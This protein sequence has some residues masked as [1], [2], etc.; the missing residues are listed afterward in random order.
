ME[1]LPAGSRN[2][3]CLKKSVRAVLFDI[4]GTLFI[5]GSGDISSS[6]EK[7]Q[8]LIFSRLLENY[9]IKKDAD[10]VKKCYFDE[11]ANE[12]N[13]LREAGIDYPEVEIDIIWMKALGID[14][15]Q[16]AR[17][18][19]VEFESITNPVWPMPGLREVIGF[20]KKKNI[21]IGVIS[22]AQFFSPILFEVFTGFNP[23]ELGF[24]NDLMFFSFEHK[25]A[26][27]STM[28]Y[29][30]AKKVLEEKSIAA[31]NTLYVGNDMLNDIYPADAV[32]FQTVLFAGDMRSLR[33]R[34]NDA[35]CLKLTPDLVVS[36][37]ADISDYLNRQ[38]A[39][40]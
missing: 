28:L 10:E 21:M 1:P 22:N 25:Y 34:K 6:G 26:K 40:S 29:L 7:I 39:W 30:K 18:F 31:E 35:R 24:S 36:T 33:L 11:I 3:G 2:Q 12:H 14:N 37:L 13:R 17:R 8:P 19:S 23:E 38:N 16:F 32:G 20:L 27:P 15:L 5:S 9:G 4:Y